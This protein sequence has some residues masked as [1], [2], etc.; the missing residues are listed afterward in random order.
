MKIFLIRLI[1]II[2]YNIGLFCGNILTKPFFILTLILRKIYSGYIA[3]KLHKVGKNF[4]TYYPLHIIGSQSIFI[5]DNFSSFRRNRIEV[6]AINNY[7]GKLTIG[8]NFSMNDDCHLA[9]INN[10]SI[11]NNVLIASKVFITDHFH[12]EINS[13]QILIPPSNRDLYSKGPVVIG[14]NVWIGEG[15]V[16]LPG[17]SIGE[18]SIIGANSVVSKSIEKNTV[19]AGNPALKIKSL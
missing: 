8:N 1:L 16:I 7:K 13:D 11:G 14:D 6:F 18:N 12:G 3:S 17:V 4:N 2:S 19:V 15:A 5:G 10:I 9:V